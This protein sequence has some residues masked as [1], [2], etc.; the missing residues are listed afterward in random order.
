MPRVQAHSPQ[1]PRAL[2]GWDGVGVLPGLRMCWALSPEPGY[3]RDGEFGIRIEDVVLVVEAQT[4][5]P[6]SPSQGS[7]WGRGARTQPWAGSAMGAA[8]GRVGRTHLLTSPAAPYRGEAFPDLRGGV[9][10]AI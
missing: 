3:Y 10:G 8:P 5:V 2:Q 7:A 1:L 6:P 4:K 9:P